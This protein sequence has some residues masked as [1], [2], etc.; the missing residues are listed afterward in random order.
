MPLKS[1]NR[2]YTKALGQF[3][4]IFRL[5]INSLFGQKIISGDIKKE[6][7]GRQVFFNLANIS[8]S[9]W[10]PLLM[11][12]CVLFNTR[13]SLTNRSRISQCTASRIFSRCEEPTKK[14][15]SRGRHKF[16][17]GRGPGDDSHR[18]LGTLNQTVPE[19]KPRPGRFFLGASGCPLFFE[20]A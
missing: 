11:P 15:S 14:G 5:A 9:H 20:R 19:R 17:P 3:Q 1:L 7:P 8:E 6:Y 18:A 4:H 10:R 13:H 16:A 2:V 12:G